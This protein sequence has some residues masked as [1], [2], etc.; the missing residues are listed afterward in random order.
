MDHECIG[1]AL[2]SLVDVRI[3]KGVDA[4]L[5]PPATAK[6]S[7]RPVSWHFSKAWGMVTARLVSMR[8]AQKLSVIL[9]SVKGTGWKG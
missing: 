1:S 6:L 4:A 3:V 7:M 9:T 5:R 2:Q 8:G